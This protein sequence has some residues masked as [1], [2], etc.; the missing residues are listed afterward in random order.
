MIPKSKCDSVPADLV[1]TIGPVRDNGDGPYTLER[2]D[3]KW[4]LICSLGTVVRQV[5]DEEVAEMR[6]SL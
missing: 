3:G 2:R 4:F 1:V 6:I 5:S